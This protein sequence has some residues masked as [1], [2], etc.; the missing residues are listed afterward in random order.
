MA[1][2]NLVILAGL[3]AAGL[4]VTVSVPPVLMKTTTNRSGFPYMF[5]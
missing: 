2:L 4:L 5:V 1:G 3:P